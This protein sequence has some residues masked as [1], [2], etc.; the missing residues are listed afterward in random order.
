LTPGR[1]NWKDSEEHS[2]TNLGDDG[3]VVLFFEPK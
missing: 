2:G 1:V 3:I